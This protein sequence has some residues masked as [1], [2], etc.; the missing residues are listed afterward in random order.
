[1]VTSF[2]FWPEGRKGDMLVLSVD[3]G[4]GVGGTWRCIGLESDPQLMGTGAP[5][6]LP[7]AGSNVFG[8]LSELASEKDVK[9][10]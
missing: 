4:V 7:L 3:H 10:N 9:R 1:M 6:T 5:L 8:W 2:Q